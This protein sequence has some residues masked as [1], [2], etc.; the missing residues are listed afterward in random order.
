MV[1]EQGVVTL[2]N[3]ALVPYKEIFEE[4][5]TVVAWDGS[6]KTAAAITGDALR[7]LFYHSRFFFYQ[8]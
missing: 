8:F 5:G 1:L 6:T 4:L 2:N 7:I 3:R